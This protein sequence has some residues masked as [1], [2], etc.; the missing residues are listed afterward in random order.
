M[1]ATHITDVAE[2]YD[3]TSLKGSDSRRAI[4]SEGEG[5]RHRVLLCPLPPEEL[6]QGSLAAS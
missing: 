2:L 1:L 5:V 3:L 4:A 6:L